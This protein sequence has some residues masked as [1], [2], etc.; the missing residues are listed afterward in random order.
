MIDKVLKA[1]F[2]N[3]AADTVAFDLIGYRL[4]WNYAGRSDFRIITETEAYIGPD[5]LSLTCC[6]RPNQTNRGHGG[7]RNPSLG[8]KLSA[9][10]DLYLRS[11]TNI[12]LTC[13]V[14]PLIAIRRASR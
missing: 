12:A 6:E 4:C 2:F 7:D 5:D 1:D 14:C 8:T 10:I 9:V 13:R 11:K 3:R